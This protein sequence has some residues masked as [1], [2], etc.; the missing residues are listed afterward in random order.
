V[1][2]E[3]IAASSSTYRVWRIN[4]STDNIILGGGDVPDDP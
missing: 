4:N 2:A 3:R 1:T